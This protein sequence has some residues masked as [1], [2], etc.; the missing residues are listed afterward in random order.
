MA[1]TEQRQERRRVREQQEAASGGKTP[2]FLACC[3]LSALFGPTAVSWRVLE[4][5]FFRGGAWAEMT[6]VANT[7][8][9]R[10]PEVHV[11]HPILGF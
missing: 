8:I 9:H 5:V 1:R 2:S 6:F 10:L 3:P 11:L 7:R 4:A